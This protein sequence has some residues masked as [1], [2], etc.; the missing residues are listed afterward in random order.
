M[1]SLDFT[2]N[3]FKSR[4]VFGKITFFHKSDAESR[5]GEDHHAKSILQKMSACM[6]SKNKKKAVLNLL[7]HPAHTG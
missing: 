5:L 7:I 6:R 2:D 4:L 3:L 1:I